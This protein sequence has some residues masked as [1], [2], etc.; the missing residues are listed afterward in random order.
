VGTP[1]IAGRPVAA[2]EVHDAS[3]RHVRSRFVGRSIAR[4]EVSIPPAYA[5]RNPFGMPSEYGPTAYP[6]GQT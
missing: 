1:V 2:L 4:R 5:P 6:Y 3:V